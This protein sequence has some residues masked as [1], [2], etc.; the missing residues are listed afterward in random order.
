MIYYIYSKGDL[1][2]ET[3]SVDL[4][5]TFIRENPDCSVKDAVTGKEFTIKYVKKPP[6]KTLG[7]PVG[8]H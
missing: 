4:V 6:Q 8:H 5:K 2:A 3:D 1:I 7:V